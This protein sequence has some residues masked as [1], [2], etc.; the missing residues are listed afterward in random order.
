[1]SIIVAAFGVFVLG[2][3]LLGM[4]RPMGLMAVVDRPWRTPAGLYMAMVFRLAL[5]VIFLAGASG[6]RFPRIIGGIG[7]LSVLSAFAIPFI[8]YPRARRFIDWWLNQ[9]P[10]FIRAWSGVACAFGAFL[11]CAAV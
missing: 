8:G 2:L 1:M 9:T 4:I 7:I 11:I 3:G 5:G 6:T 10:G